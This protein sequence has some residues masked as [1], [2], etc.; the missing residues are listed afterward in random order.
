MLAKLLTDKDRENLKKIKSQ[1]DRILYCLEKFG[2]IT[3]NDCVYALGIAAG[4]RRI[5]DL[6]DK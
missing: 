3:V 4:P 6:R 5:K 1:R 2:K